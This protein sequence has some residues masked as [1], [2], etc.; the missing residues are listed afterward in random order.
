VI[1]LRLSLLR[2]N[3]PGERFSGHEEKNRSPKEKGAIT[4]TQETENGSF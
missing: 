4:R 2:P 3:Y 1:L